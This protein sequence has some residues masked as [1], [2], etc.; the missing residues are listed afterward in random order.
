MSSP[1]IIVS[2]S[3]VDKQR[4][5]DVC[6]KTGRKISSWT[7]TLLMDAVYEEEERLKEKIAKDSK[8]P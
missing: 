2:L 6:E 3:N 7:R 8:L 4:L 5:D 1:R